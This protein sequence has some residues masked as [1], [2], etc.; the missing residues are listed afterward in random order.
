MTDLIDREELRKRLEPLTSVGIHPQ[1]RRGIFQALVILDGLPLA[2]CETCLHWRAFNGDISLGFGVCEAVRRFC[3]T[4]HLQTDAKFF[5]S[6]YQPK[7]T[8]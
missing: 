3:I 5:C 1:L 2:T 4:N 7:G 6:Y 8:S